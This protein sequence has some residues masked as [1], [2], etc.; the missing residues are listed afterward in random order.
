MAKKDCYEIYIRSRSNK[1]F[2]ENIG[3]TIRRKQ[4]RLEEYIRRIRRPEPT[5]VFPFS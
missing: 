3:F 4:I 5:P 2:Y 1:D